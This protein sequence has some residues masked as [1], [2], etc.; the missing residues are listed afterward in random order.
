MG[1]IRRSLNFQGM[2][3]RILCKHGM[4]TGHH[5]HQGS[6]PPA[7]IR[8]HLARLKAEIVG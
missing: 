8:E 1:H 4:G 5:Q 7:S 2:P 3:T 6:P